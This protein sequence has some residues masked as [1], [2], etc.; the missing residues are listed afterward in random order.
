MA[1]VSTSKNTSIFYA[2]SAGKASASKTK[3]IKRDSQIKSATDQIVHVQILNESTLNLTHGSV[4][5]LKRSQARLLD[6]QGKVLKEVNLAED[7]KSEA[8]A[9]SRK[10]EQ[11]QVKGIEDEGNA[12]VN[13]VRNNQ[14]L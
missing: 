12:R 8:K 3:V 13:G 4:Y 14:G 2:K 5:S 6:D 11:Y 7:V 1:A 10:E 9:I